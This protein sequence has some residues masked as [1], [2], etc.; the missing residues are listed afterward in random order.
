MDA[1]DYYSKHAAAYDAENGEEDVVDAFRVERDRFL[2][3]LSGD[4]VLDAGCG[5]GRD[6]HRFTVEGLDAYWVDV[7]EAM[8]DGA[9]FTVENVET[10][11]IGPDRV[12]AQYLCTR[13][14][15]P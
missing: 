5:P 13:H 9:G 15:Q 11:D 3:A 10:A 7:A 4:T 12:F 1:R 14:A 8:L 6:V 2:D